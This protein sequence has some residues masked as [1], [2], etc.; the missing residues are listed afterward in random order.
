VADTRGS[1]AT[2]WVLNLPSFNYYILYIAIA[3]SLTP[4]LYKYE[5]LFCYSSHLQITNVIVVRPPCACTCEC[6]SWSVLHLQHEAYVR[7]R[8][9]S[10][11]LFSNI[12]WLSLSFKKLEH[13]VVDEN[14][15]VH[16]LYPEIW[17][18][19]VCEGIECAGRSTDTNTALR[20]PTRHHYFHPLSRAL[21]HMY[22]Q[23]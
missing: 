5:T 6:N 9:R 4:L 8:H 17:A 10:W 12:L 14:N 13:L 16:I 7:Q 22:V 15:K 20:N 21:S 3:S 11:S 1:T 2:T 23:N 18:S 19:L